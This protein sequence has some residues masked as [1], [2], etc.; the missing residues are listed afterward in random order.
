MQYV[1]CEEEY[2]DAMVR[3]VFNAKR[4]ARELQVQVAMQR[5]ENVELTKK[6]H[7]ALAKIA[8]L[9]SVK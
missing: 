9:E 2:R 5:T 3:N 8:E 7:E 6:Y 1:A 4:E